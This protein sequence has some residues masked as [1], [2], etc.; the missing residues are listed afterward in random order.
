MSLFTSNHERRL[1][2]WA[3]A[4]MVGIY[5]TLGP[6]R[7]LAGALRE[8]GMLAL[9]V[10]LVLILVVG[11]LAVPWIKRR[12]DRQEVFVALG[13]ALA[14]LMVGWRIESWEERTF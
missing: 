10:G 6:A 14:F 2:L 13:V 7:V 1:W 9:S 3:L 12:P 4:V 5:S 8:R 11:A